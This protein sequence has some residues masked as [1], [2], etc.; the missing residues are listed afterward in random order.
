MQIYVGLIRLFWWNAKLKIQ[1]SMQYRADFLV[2]LVISL[3]FSSV[4]PVFQYLIFTQTRGYPGWNLR[5]IILFQGILLLWTG[6][7]EL[8]FGEIPYLAIELVRKGDFDRLL[9]KPYPPIGIILTGGFNFSSIGTIAA[10]LVITFYSMNAM[11]LGI[12]LLQ[13]GQLLL[14]LSCGLVFIMAIYI[15]YCSI[16]IMVIQMQ[17]I[18]EILNNLLRFADFPLEI[19]SKTAKVVLTTV[20]PIIIWNYVPAQILL[21]RANPILF[22]S[23]IGCLVFMALSLKIWNMC[24]KRYTSAGG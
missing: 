22:I 14:C 5:Q 19:F 18:I 17:R 6:S 8:L 20:I 16:M 15:L 11:K 12:S 13:M 7:R 1:R 9:L 4:G 10:G 3:G 23:C 21:Q 2:G 24:L